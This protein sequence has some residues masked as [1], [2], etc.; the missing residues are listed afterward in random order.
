MVGSPACRQKGNYGCHLNRSS[1]SRTTCPLKNSANRLTLSSMGD[2]MGGAAGTGLACSGWC[3]AAAAGLTDGSGVASAGGMAAAGC[4]GAAIGGGAAAG[5]AGWELT[6]F[7]CPVTAATGATAA[8]VGG[9][10]GAAAADVDAGVIAPL[11]LSS[12]NWRLPPQ[13]LAIACSSRVARLCTIP[14]QL[15]A[16]CTT[17]RW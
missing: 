14:I 1:N 3:D 16:T 11:W 2:G 13:A 10:G 17:A 8:G 4:G 6:A 15:P 9:D 5:T 12:T 7:A